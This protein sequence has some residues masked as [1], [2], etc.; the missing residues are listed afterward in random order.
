M[1]TLKLKV[2]GIDISGVKYTCS[3]PKAIV[4]VSHGL[5]EH[6]GRYDGFFKEMVFAG[7][8]VYA[9][10]FPGHGRSGGKRGATS[11]PVMVEVMASFLEFAKKENPSV[12][13]SLFGHSMGGLVALRCLKKMQEEFSCAAVSAPLVAFK[14]EREKTIKNSLFLGSIFPFLTVDN[15]IIIDDLSRNRSIVDAYDKDPL[16]HRRVALSLACSFYK[17]IQDT[18]GME[19]SLPLLVASGTSDRVVPYEGVKD[20]YNGIRSETK[21]FIPFEGAYHEIFY[22]PQHGDTFRK[23]IIQWL[24]TRSKS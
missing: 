21:R 4:M 5:G 9:P 23:E 20:F 19:L 12:P 15:G 17:E 18:L 24:L 1:E 2:K 3:S 8:S 14:P 6:T 7:L 11:I 10:D 13:F 16:V 22:D